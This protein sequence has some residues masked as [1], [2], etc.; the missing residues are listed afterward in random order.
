MKH[1][2]RM[3]KGAA[4]ALVFALSHFE[5]G[6]QTLAI[7]QPGPINVGRTD[8]IV[9]PIGQPFV[10]TQDSGVVRAVNCAD[11]TCSSVSSTHVV[12]NLTASRL[13]VALGVDGLPV[14]SIS[15]LNNGLRVVKCQTP[16]CNVSTT[17]ILEPGNLGLT[18]HSMV[19]PP[20]GRP[21]LAYYDGIAGDLKYVRC[22]DAACLSGNQFSIVDSA[23]TVGRATAMALVGG[24]PQIAYN[25]DSSSLRLAMCNTLDC[26]GATF[27]S[28]APDNALHASAMTAR[29][30][31][32]LVA[33]MVDTV[34]NDSVKVAKCSNA[35]CASVAI[36]TIDQI[37]GATIGIGV[38]ITAGKDGLPVMSYFD[39]TA[40]SIKLARCTRT[41][42]T[43][44]TV[45][46]VH[47]PTPSLLPTGA[48]NGLAI[49]VAGTPVLAYSHSNK[50][51][52][53]SCNTR[54]CQ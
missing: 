41:D 19:I 21:V 6:A 47:A 3:L 25:V 40:A 38:R 4:C 5:V 20:D 8:L 51:T 52:I 28:L 46:T 48:A 32:I 45:T 23:G 13:R 11:P 10:V 18:D 35:L 15:I 1:L 22:G 50:L 12:A 42:C 16:A 54:S 17:S 37:P 24:V 9:Y 30:G 49:S 33:Y 7:T 36:T 14:I 44:S 53:H 2:D 26:L 34:S 39:A 43:T 27:K 31:S 29:D